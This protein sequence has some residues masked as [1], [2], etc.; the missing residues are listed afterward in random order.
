[1]SILRLALVIMVVLTS[2]GHAFEPTVANMPP[3]VRAVSPGPGDV[4]VDPAVGE[5]RIIFSKDMM[6]DRQW[7]LVMYSK[8]TFPRITGPIHFLPD[9]KTCVV[10]VGLDP[11]RTYVIWINSQ[12]HTGFR[13]LGNRPATPYLWVFQ[14]RSR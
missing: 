6:T 14:T 9:K 5:L 8:E 13:D 11:G 4:N 10:P 12:Q 1:M 7:S 3:A 2:T